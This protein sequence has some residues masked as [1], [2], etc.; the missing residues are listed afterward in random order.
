MPWA[1]RTEEPILDNV[2]EKLHNGICW[3]NA[4]QWQPSASHGKLYPDVFNHNRHIAPRATLLRYV[5]QFKDWCEHYCILL[6]K[7][8]SSEENTWWSMK[9]TLYFPVEEVATIVHKHH[10]NYGIFPV[11]WG[12]WIDALRVLHFRRH[13]H[14]ITTAKSNCKCSISPLWIGIMS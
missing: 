11:V 6:I 7:S 5:N 1:Y 14:A 4:S 10:I 2:G 13:A 12:H 3:P 9:V 8:K